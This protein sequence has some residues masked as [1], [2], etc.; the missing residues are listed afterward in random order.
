MATVCTF[1]KSIVMSYHFV[2]TG[3][4]SPTQRSCL[5]GT[6]AYRAPEL[7]RGLPPCARADVYSFGVTMW[8]MLSRR[9]VNI[10]LSFNPLLPSQPHG[11]KTNK[12][13]QEF[14]IFFFKFS[15]GPYPA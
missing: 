14:S 5:T 4:V 7:L 15:D 9:Q 1:S 8:E 10:N 6:Y 13:K 11:R 12:N 2:G 3:R